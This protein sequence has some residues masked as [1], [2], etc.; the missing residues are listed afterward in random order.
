MGSGQTAKVVNNASKSMHQSHRGK[1]LAGEC[2][3]VSQLPE[4]SVRT[5][6]FISGQSKIFSTPPSHRIIFK[7]TLCKTNKQTKKNTKSFKT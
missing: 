3:W 2:K 7:L 4:E 1:P 6:S 5:E